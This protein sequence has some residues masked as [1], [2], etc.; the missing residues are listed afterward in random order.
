MLTNHP[1]DFVLVQ[2]HYADSYGTAWG[3]SRWSYFGFTGLPSAAFDDFVKCIGAYTNDTSQYNWYN[4]T[5]YAA[6]KAVATDV[7]MDIGGQFVSGQTYRI[8]VKVGLEATGTAKTVRVYTTQVLDYW[9]AT[10]GYHRNGFKQ[11]A[12]YLDVALTPGQETVF[13]RDFTLD[14]D[15]NNNKANVKIIAWAQPPGAA[16]QSPGAYQAHQMTWPFTPLLKHG[17]MNCDG[18]VDSG[19]IDP[20]FLAL[21]DPAAWQ[22]QNPNC[23]LLNGDINGDQTMDS[24]DI[25]PFFALLQ[26]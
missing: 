24:G 8:S 13:T 9:P 20:F 5:G 3:N 10:S 19:D 1:N 2:Y 15:S 12:A 14:T 18:V 22:T 16:Y 11:A 7:T 25:D 4:G 17:D 21:Q 23:P 26:G 6:R